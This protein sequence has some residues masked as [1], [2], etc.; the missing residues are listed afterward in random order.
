MRHKGAA[1]ALLRITLGLILTFYGIGKL[2]MGPS[3][4]ANGLVTQFSKT[5]L[6]APLVHAFGLILPYT[7]LLFGVLLVLGAFTTATL[8]LTALQFIALTLG[9]VLQ[10]QTA[11]VAQNL[12]YALVTFFLLFYVEYNWAALDALGRRRVVLETEVRARR[13]A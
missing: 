8:V 12:L 1:Y 7:E 2:M 13:V 6:P 5:F 11:V 3:A 10:Q 4:F 9:M